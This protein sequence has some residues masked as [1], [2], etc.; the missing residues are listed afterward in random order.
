MG[1]FGGNSEK[2]L[3]K[4]LRRGDNGAM[5]DFYALY[6]AHLSGVCSRYIANNADRDDVFQDSLVSIIQHIGDFEYRGD[7]SLK[8][9]ATRIVVNQALTFLHNSKRIDTVAIEQDVGD[10]ADVGEP[11]TDDLPPS[12]LHDM[13]RRLPDG[14]RAVF[15]LYV[16]ENKS[17]RE[18]AR[19]L[20]IKEATS[21]SQ[22]HRAKALLAR[23]INEYR[24]N[25]RAQQ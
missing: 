11:A 3:A 23:E 2:D 17:H 8:A 13:I 25:K 15:N 24:N 10:V 1:L 19:L 5:R 12:V 21:A 16:V 9:W 6:A 20:N 4:R 18:I 14:Y 22:L 7:G